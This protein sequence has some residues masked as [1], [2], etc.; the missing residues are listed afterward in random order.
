MT[1]FI[2]GGS[3]I[4]TDGDCSYEIKRRL[5]LGRKAMRNLDRIFKSRDIILLTKVHI[6]KAVVF[7][8]VRC[9]YASWTIKKAECW[10]IDAFGL[11]CWRRLKNPLDCKEIKPINP[12]G[13]QPWIFILWKD[14]CWSFG[15][16]MRRADSLEKTLMLGKMGAREES[17]RGWDG[18]LASPTQWTWVWATLR[19]S[20]GQG[21]LAC[22]SSQGHKESDM[23]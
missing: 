19:D 7:P 5:L 16:L 1:N 6:V 22:C 21:R 4:T 15:H 8:V 2:L 17:D 12:K 10:R 13:N 3:K 18:W 11:L 14:W 20:E 23:T 9:K